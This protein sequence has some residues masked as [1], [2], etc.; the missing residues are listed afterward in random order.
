MILWDYGA[1]RV[2]QAANV[3][4]M[5]QLNMWDS[6]SMLPALATCFPLPRNP[7]ENVDLEGSLL[8]DTIVVVYIVTIRYTHFHMLGISRVPRTLR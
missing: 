6:G 1:S 3:E 4:V 2:P 8:Y 7:S 5:C